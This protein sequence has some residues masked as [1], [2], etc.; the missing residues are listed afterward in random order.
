[1]TRE[2]ECDGSG[3]R[4][5][6]VPARALIPWGMTCKTPMRALL[7]IGCLRLLPLAAMPVESDMAA[8]TPA[9]VLSL[10]DA[11]CDNKVHSHAGIGCGGA[12]GEGRHWVTRAQTVVFGHFA[13]PDSDD[14]ILAGYDRLLRSGAAERQIDGR[15]RAR[16]F[17][18]DPPHPARRR[19]A[20]RRLR[21]P[22][23]HPAVRKSQGGV[24]G[25]DP[26]VPGAPPA[27]SRYPDR[28]ALL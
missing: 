10:L 20:C 6:H 22:C 17:G 15:D 21:A 11:I 26:R 14:A 28:A 7:L 16:S 2:R 13:S 12:P 5:R 3:L 8:P 9:V 25:G 27:G 4:R 19:M 23:E 1:M 18:N 24:R